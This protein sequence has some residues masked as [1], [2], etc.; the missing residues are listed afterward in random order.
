MG[1][2]AGVSRAFLATYRPLCGTAAG[3]VAVETY[4]LKPYVDASCR[5]EPDLEGRWP[6]ITA[7]CRGRNFAPRLREGDRVA[8]MTRRLN[9]VWYLTAMLEVVQ[10]FES[11]ASAADWYRAMGVPLPSNCMVAGNPPLPLSHTEGLGAGC[12]ELKEWDEF[13]QERAHKHG[14]L[15]RCNSLF[16][17]LEAPPAITRDDWQAWIGR[18]PATRTPPPISETLW[19][20]LTWGATSGSSRA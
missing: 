17:S 13:Y 6:T 5:R 16:Q 15:L 2:T 10:R 19:G 4:G 18:M 1:R 9:G 11:H 8:Y 14:V 7:L 3:R 20:R 12:T